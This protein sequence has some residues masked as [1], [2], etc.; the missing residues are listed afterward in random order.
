MSEEWE[1]LLGNLVEQPS[2][3]ANQ[4]SI[5][6]RPEIIKD[7][8]NTIHNQTTLQVYDKNE[9]LKDHLHA[10]IFPHFFQLKSSQRNETVHHDY[11]T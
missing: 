11:H 4:A 10:T 9:E 7:E 3:C 2:L 8:R 5:D 1:Q 6:Q